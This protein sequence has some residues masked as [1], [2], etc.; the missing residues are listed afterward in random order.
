MFQGHYEPWLPENLV[1]TTRPTVTV[2]K[3]WKHLNINAVY[4]PNW[5]EYLNES[6]VLF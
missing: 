6:E 5:F 3:E 2:K 4:L 1:T